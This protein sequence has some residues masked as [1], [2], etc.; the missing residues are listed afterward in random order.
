MSSRRE[1][2]DRAAGRHT[3]S[4][5]PLPV[6]TAPSPSQRDLYKHLINGCSSV[7][8]VDF[9]R[10]IV[11]LNNT[12]V[13]KQPSRPRR[14]FVLIFTHHGDRYSRTTQTDIHTPHRYSR[15]T[16]KSPGDVPKGLC[17][18]YS[19]IMQGF[20]WP[21][22]ATRCKHAPCGFCRTLTHTAELKNNNSYTAPTPLHQQ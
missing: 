14:V 4:L 22:R 21:K 5:L 7:S 8:S 18:R 1:P 6:S 15:T 19:R 2:Q 13:T 20:S 16:H 11:F 9:L 17:G 3:V 10:V 12:C